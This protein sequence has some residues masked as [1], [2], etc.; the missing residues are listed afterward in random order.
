MYFA[1]GSCMSVASLSATI[2]ADTLPF[3]LGAGR[4]PGWRLAFNYPSTNGKDF[5][6][7]IVPDA[8]DATFGALYRL[9]AACREAVR[10]R[11]A[12]HK[13][14]YR[15]EVVRVEALGRRP[16]W[17]EALTYVANV[18]AAAE[19]DPGERYARLVLEGARQCGTPPDYIARLEA[20]IAGLRGLAAS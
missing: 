14:R 10:T 18:A 4:L 15:E 16:G 5:F 6:C 12:W 3:L 1:Y 11:E 17:L 2:G 13:Q 20:R 7:N 19:G 9:P 8:S